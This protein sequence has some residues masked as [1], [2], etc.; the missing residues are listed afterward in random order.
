MW[1]TWIQAALYYYEYFEKIK[2]IVNL[3]N[4]NNANLL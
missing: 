2:L 1:G 3:F 4:K